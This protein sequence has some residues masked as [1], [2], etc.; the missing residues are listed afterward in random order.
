M[1]V[2]F[3]VGLGEKEF[4]IFRLKTFQHVFLI[5]QESIARPHDEVTSC[6][7]T[8]ASTNLQNVL[9]ILYK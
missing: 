4:T 6:I 3:C 8:A 5:N 9:K 7:V 1:K 2:L